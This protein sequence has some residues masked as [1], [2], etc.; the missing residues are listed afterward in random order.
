MAINVDTVYQKVLALANKEQRGYI[1]PQE[2]NLF[3]NQ[4]Q[5]AIFEQY[6]YDLNQFRRVPGNDTNYADMVSLL[7]QKI[8]IF[9]HYAD[10]LTT[11][12]WEDV[13]SPG[14]YSLPNAPNNIYRISQ[15]IVDGKNVEIV[16]SKDFNNF[17]NSP[18]TKPTDSRPIATVTR[19][20]IAGNPSPEG[21]LRVS[22]FGDLEMWYIRKPVDVNWGYTVFTGGQSNI[23]ALYNPGISTDFE[24]HASDQGE[25]VNRILGLA[26]ISI[27]KPELTQVAAGL[28]QGKVQQEKQ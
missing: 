20:G 1:T 6:F 23:D 13:D 16:N 8:Q 15:I 21:V 22:K 26:G 3:A 7:E 4:A 25:L 5:M 9:E 24:L 27:Q 2:F 12:N 18:L 10:P 19:V 11:T 14:E 17:A 28:E